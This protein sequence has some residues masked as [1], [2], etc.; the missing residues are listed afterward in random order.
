MTGPPVVVFNPVSGLDAGD[1]RDALTAVGLTDVR[2]I[3][4]TKDDPGVRASREAVGDQAALVV[5]CGGDG[6]V[7]ACVT[8][9]AGSDVPLAVIPAGTG[10]LLARNFAIDRTLAGAAAIAATGVRRRIDVGML[11]NERFAIM[12]GVGFDAQMLRDAPRQ[13]KD[14]VGWLAY[15]ISGVRTARQS[16]TAWFRLTLDGGTV[17]RRRGRGVLIGNVGDLQAGL[18]VLPGAV[19]DDGTFEIGLLAART[20]RDWLGLLARLVLRGTPR[21]RQLEVFTAARVDV[22]V[23][24]E[25]PLQ[26][27]G[28]VRPPTRQFTAAVLPRALTLCVPADAQAPAEDQPEESA[29]TSV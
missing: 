23:D 18:P 4:T 8:G 29:A 2:W 10:N 15:V 24:R 26:L 1:V 11:G 6:T 12:A 28:D 3:E 19:P 20:A 7:M 27:D 16:P 17:V 5:A 22:A 9:L 21:E 25:L 14:K 13:L